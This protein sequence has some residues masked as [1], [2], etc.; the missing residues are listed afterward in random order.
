MSD[1]RER[2]DDGASD[3]EETNT[4]VGHVSQGGSITPGSSSEEERNES[5]A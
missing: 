3:G 5:E 2:V 1:H 4:T